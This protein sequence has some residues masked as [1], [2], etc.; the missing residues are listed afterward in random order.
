LLKIK[1]FLRDRRARFLTIPESDAPSLFHA[2]SPIAAARGLFL[3]I[4]R[5]TPETNGNYKAISYRID[6]TLSDIMT[7][8]RHIERTCID[9]EDEDF[10]A[11]SL[12]REKF[13]VLYHQEPY[14][15][16]DWADKKFEK[17]LS[18]EAYTS[19]ITKYPQLK[20]AS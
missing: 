20:K 13:H 4:P 16:L 10:A 5:R 3:T 7:A 17:Y 11:A 9:N 8:L 2:L 14:Y 18:S 19:L 12:S 6:N 1:Q 15:V